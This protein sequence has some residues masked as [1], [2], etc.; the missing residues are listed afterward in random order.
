[1]S[2]VP[3]PLAVQRFTERITAVHLKDFVFDTAAR[4][5]DVPVGE[6]NLNL[7]AFLRALNGAGFEGVPILEYEAD[8]DDP[9]PALTQCVRRV[10]EAAASEG[11][12]L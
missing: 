2:A 11:F 6:G 8:T 4:W 9:L 1:M 5:A 12:A 7:P 10:R 3:F